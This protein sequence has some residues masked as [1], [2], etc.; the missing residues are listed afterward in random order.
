MDIISRLPTAALSMV[1]AGLAACVVLWLVSSLSNPHSRLSFRGIVLLS[2][3]V[4]CA[5]FFKTLI[6]G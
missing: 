3:L 1:V 6:W 2:G 4:G 5:M